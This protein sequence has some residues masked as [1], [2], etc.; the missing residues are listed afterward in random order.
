MIHRSPLPPLDVSQ[1]DG[2][3]LTIVPRT[4]LDLA[5]TFSSEHLARACHEAWVHHQTSAGQIQACIARN[6]RKKGIAKLRRALGA[7]VTLSALESGF[8]ALLVEHDLPIP[9][10][11][12]V[13]GGDKV[14]CHWPAHGLTIELLSFR[15]HASRYAFEADVARR[16]RSQHIAYTYGDVFERG[17]ETVADLRRRLGART[18]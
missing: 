15:F 14:D 12:I 17:R 2:I 11:N 13:R 16:R 1:F 10:T 7:E 6:P 9:R 4:L 18:A 8:L 3:P 5:A